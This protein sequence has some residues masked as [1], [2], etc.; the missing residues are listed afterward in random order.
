[1][2]HNTTIIKRP[3]IS[4]KS[5]LLAQKGWYTFAVSKNARK[6]TIAKAIRA[7][8]NVQV[9]EIRTMRKTGKTRR[10]GRSMR[11]VTRPD[12]K[13]AMVALAKGQTIPVFEVTRE[14]AKG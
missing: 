4:E 14:G 11:T 2:V 9:T 7:L 13:K 5:M 8:Y 10:V 12:W 1:M 3:V 6:E